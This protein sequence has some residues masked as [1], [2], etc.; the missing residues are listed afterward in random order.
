M[1]VTVT[2]VKKRLMEAIKKSITIRKT[3]DH[4][5][6]EFRHERF[7]VMFN[8]PKEFELGSHGILGIRGAT[9]KFSMEIQNPK[10]EKTKS[11]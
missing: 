2:D 4:V 7:N 10:K 8:L 11:E 1:T 9:V 5:G 6:H 3:H